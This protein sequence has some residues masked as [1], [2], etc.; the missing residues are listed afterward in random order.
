MSSYNYADYLEN[1]QNTA[2]KTVSKQNLQK[3][4]FFKLKDDGDV[5]LVRFNIGSTEDLKFAIGHTINANGRW[6]RV[7]CLNPINKFRSDD[8]PLCRANA[9]GDTSISIASKK[10]YIQ[11][12]VAYKDN[13]TGSISAAEPVVWERP[14]SFSREIANLL[15]DFGDLREHVFKVTRNGA[16]GDMKTTYTIGYVPL[17]DK[18]DYVPADLSAFDNFN[19]AKHSYWE[20]TEDEIRA[21]LET[22][23][24]PEVQRAPKADTVEQPVYTAS[25]VYTA[26]VQEEPKEEPTPAPKAEPSI[27]TY[28]GSENYPS[29]NFSS[30]TF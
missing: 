29:R 12:L 9:G 13:T 28:K 11:M 6:M 18:P 5:A 3:I 20:K 19:I 4:G 10:V 16:A 2:S 17:Y 22:G 24:F 14:D 30:F 25:T 7:S 8:C 21:F 27:N 26:P 1:Q 15:N 23:S